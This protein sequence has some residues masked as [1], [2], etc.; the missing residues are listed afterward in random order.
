[1]NEQKH[2]VKQILFTIWRAVYPLLIY[3]GWSYVASF[4]LCFIG[5]FIMMYQSQGAMNPQQMTT[6]LTDF[7]YRNVLPATIATQL[8]TMPFVIWFYRRDQRKN[9]AVTKKADLHPLDIIVLI[10]LSVSCCI[11]LNGLINYSHLADLFPGFSQVAASLYTSSR[12][13][14]I[15]SMV[16]LAPVVEEMLCRILS[17][18]RLK[19]TF[20]PIT[21]MILSSLFFG[22]LHMNVV[23]GVYAFGIGMCFVL[24]YEKTRRIFM[25]MLAH[26]I[27]NAVSLLISNNSS[28]RLF[29][30]SLTAEMA[31][32]AACTVL[33]IG[34]V[35]YFV[36]IH[37]EPDNSPVQ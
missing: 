8:L 1:M 25:P 30:L 31:M 33:L 3:L 18:N 27:A 4:V 5:I 37:R 7:I 22:L 12:F 21:A 19:E 17:Y 24:I 15:I 29:K 16:I 14:Q 26:G 2:S 35:I 6:E 34:C 36:R 11:S 32:V 20:K 28:E 10:I 13:L 9:T 23:Q